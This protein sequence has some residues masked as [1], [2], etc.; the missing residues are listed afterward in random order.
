MQPTAQA[1][2]VKKVGSHQAPK[3]RKNRYH[4][5]SVRTTPILTHTNHE[6]RAQRPVSAFLRSSRYFFAMRAKG[7]SKLVCKCR[8]LTVSE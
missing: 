5:D 8:S 1:V 2:G 3:E 6:N 7:R 4:T